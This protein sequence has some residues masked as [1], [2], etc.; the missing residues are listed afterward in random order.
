MND[1]MCKMKNE[2]AIFSYR[3]CSFIYK[4]VNSTLIASILSATKIS[5]LFDRIRNVAILTLSS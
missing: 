4:T 2:L 1:S 5:I 3:R